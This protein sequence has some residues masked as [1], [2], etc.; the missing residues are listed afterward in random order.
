[1]QE[2]AHQGPVL[3]LKYDAQFDR[4]ASVGSGAAQVWSF[5]ADRKCT[6]NDSTGCLS[7]TLLQGVCAQ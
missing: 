1:M 6:P 7:Y 4:I 2:T 5:N 3:D